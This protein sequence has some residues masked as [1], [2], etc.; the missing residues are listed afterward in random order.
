MPSPR[1]HPS[2][3]AVE[4][5]LNAGLNAQRRGSLGDLPARHARLRRLL[6]ERW[7]AHVSGTLGD[8]PPPARRAALGALVL[9]RWGLSQLR[10][11]HGAELEEIDEHAW[12]YSTSWRPLLA[13]ACHHGFI[14]VPAFP[15]RYRRRPDEAP[16]ENLCGLW[17]VG[18]STLYRYLDKGRRQLVDLFAE[19]SPTS[20]QRLELRRQAQGVLM[21]LPAP[22]PGWPAWHRDQA[23]AALLAGAVVDGLWHLWQGE[24]MAGVLDTLQRYGTEVAGSPEADALLAALELQSPLATRDRFEL[25]L[26]WVQIWRYRHDNAREDEALRRALRLAHEL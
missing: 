19:G 13:I 26:R 17:A 22:E 10:P 4:A 23:Q 3:R 12:L 6:N 1:V 7:L 8:A 24:D 21:T 25:A 2:R 5:L 20:D 18:H 15:S 14:A 16:I 11:D 9:L